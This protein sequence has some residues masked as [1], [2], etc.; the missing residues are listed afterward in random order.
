MKYGWLDSYCLSKKGA[1]KDYKPEWGATRYMVGGR[2]FAMVG[3]DK[4]GK[5]IVSLKLEPMHGETLRSEY[6]DVVPGYYLNKVHWSSVYLDGQ[7][8][9]NVLKAMLDESYRLVLE[10]LGRKAKEEVLTR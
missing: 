8:P 1:E 3:G 5:P 10:G 6:E 7:V 9:D 4:H 2:M